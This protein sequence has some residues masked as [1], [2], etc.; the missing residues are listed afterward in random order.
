VPGAEGGRGAASRE[1]RDKSQ[2]TRD[3]GT[4][5]GRRGE[6]EEGGA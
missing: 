4:G 5:E 6:G 3:K 1:P 2:E